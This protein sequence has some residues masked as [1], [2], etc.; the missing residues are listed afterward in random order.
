[1]YNLYLT[2]INVRSFLKTRNR[3][4]RQTNPRKLFLGLVTDIYAQVA[5]S[6]FVYKL[7]K[8]STFPFLSFN[9]HFV[10]GYFND[11]SRSD[12]LIILVYSDIFQLL[13]EEKELPRELK[14]V[15]NHWCQRTN[16]CWKN[17]KKIMI[18]WYD[19]LI[20]LRNFDT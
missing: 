10:F 11:L 17:V 5:L 16:Y 3:H 19:F 4:L 20:E 2:F 9:F 7:K 12:F 18:R 13:K 6:K 15:R 1:M 8:F 14:I